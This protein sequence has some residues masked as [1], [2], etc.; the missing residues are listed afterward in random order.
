VLLTSVTDGSE[1]SALRVDPFTSDVRTTGTNWIGGWVGPR[2][3]P[4]AVE[5]RKIP[6]LLLPGIETRSSSPQP[7]HYLP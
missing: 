6:L 4:D 7:S 3:G 5:K 1:W 2:A